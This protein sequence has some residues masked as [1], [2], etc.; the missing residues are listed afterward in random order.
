MIDG[1]FPPQT[2]TQNKQT[3]KCKHREGKYS[4]MPASKTQSHFNTNISCYGSNTRPWPHCHKQEV[5]KMRAANGNFHSFLFLPFLIIIKAIRRRREHREEVISQNEKTKKK[6]Q[7]CTSPP[8]VF[9]NQKVK[10]SQ[11]FVFWILIAFPNIKC[12]GN[13]EGKIFKN[14]AALSFFFCLFQCSPFPSHLILFC[15][16]HPLPIVFIP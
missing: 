2:P 9:Q 10:V 3:V 5:Y 13:S 15:Q 6:V 16:S 14:N 1:S 12:I 7:K 4:K 11:S 8:F